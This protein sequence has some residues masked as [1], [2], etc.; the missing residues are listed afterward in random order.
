MSPGYAG[1]ARRIAL[2]AP[3]PHRRWRRVL[4]SQ[5]KS[6]PNIYKPKLLSFK[7]LDLDLGLP[8]LYL[9]P[10]PRTFR[11]AGSK[12]SPPPLF[13]NFFSIFWPSKTFFK[14]SIEKSSQQVRKSRFSAPQ[15]LPKSFQNASEIDVPTNMR[16]FIDFCFKKP[17]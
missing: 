6:L 2:C 8:P 16:F 5:S 1:L 17:L 13:F 4:D 9:S 14:I 15:T 7:S 3:P 12:K 10:G 11:R